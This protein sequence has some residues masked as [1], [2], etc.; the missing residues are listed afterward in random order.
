MTRIPGPPRNPASSAI[1]SSPHTSSLPRDHPAHHSAPPTPLPRRSRIPQSPRKSAKPRSS[2][3]AA[4]L[5][6]P[7]PAAP[8]AVRRR[9]ILPHPRQLHRP[10]GRPCQHPRLIAEPAFRLGAACYPTPQNTPYS[11]D[12]PKSGCP[13]LAQLGW[14]WRAPDNPQARYH[15]LTPPRRPIAPPAGN[16]TLPHRSRPGRRLSRRH[17]ALR[18]PLRQ[19][20]ASNPPR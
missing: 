19:K 16:P 9:D 1:S 6:P 10:A 5:P 15:T 18:T 4:R 7:L 2:A 12:Q 13:T 17:H 11:P 20:G 14:A 8:A 3:H